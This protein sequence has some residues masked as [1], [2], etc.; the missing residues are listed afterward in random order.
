[1][2]NLYYNENYG[3]IIF[4]SVGGRSKCSHE[5]STISVEDPSL[6]ITFYPPQNVFPNEDMVFELEM[7]NIGVGDESQFVLYVQHRDNE[8]SLKVLLDGAPFGGSQQFTS[9]LKNTSYMKTLVVQG[10]HGCFNNHP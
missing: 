4:E 1:M 6:V 8:D 10:G 3:A 5:A 7:S 9:V 2:V